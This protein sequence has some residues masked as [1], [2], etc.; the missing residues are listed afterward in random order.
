MID[1]DS[2]EILEFLQEKGDTFTKLSSTE[3]K[4]LVELGKHFSFKS[5]LI[6]ITIHL[7]FTT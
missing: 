5:I 7:R 1:N 2:N 3:R 6:R 4:R